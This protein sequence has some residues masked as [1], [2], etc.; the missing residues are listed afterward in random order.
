M[1]LGFTHVYNDANWI[2]YSIDQAMRVCDT[3]LVVEG[4]RFMCIAGL[5]DRSDDGTLDIISDKMRTYPKRI[6]LWLDGCDTGSHRQNQNANHTAALE[7]CEIG[8]YL[9]P[10]DTDEFYTDSFIDIMNDV[11]REGEVDI[12]SWTGLWFAYGFRWYFA[13]VA[14]VALLKKVSG[15]YFISLHKPRRFGQNRMTIEKLSCHHY[16]WVKTKDRMIRR[17]GIGN[18]RGMDR[19][20]ERNYD[21]IKLAE[22][23]KIHYVQNQVFTLKKYN[24]S[25]PS[26]LDDHP[27]RN[28]DD[29]RRL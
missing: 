4:S 25:H 10:F 23:E 8:D 7:C 5:P 29:I 18:Y 17:A 26:V 13:K 9:I 28:V 2:G 27:W 14:K 21:K 12:L 20:F 22:G 24:G 6:E 1:K 11:M 3:L 16:C 15:A 19:W